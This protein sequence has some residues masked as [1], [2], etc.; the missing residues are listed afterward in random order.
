MGGSVYDYGWRDSYKIEY[1][2]G[3]DIKYGCFFDEFGWEFCQEG[4]CCQDM[5][6]FGIFIIKVW[7]FYDKSDEI[8]NLYFILNKV[9]LIN[10]NLKQN[11]GYFKQYLLDV[12]LRMK[13][14]FFFFYIKLERI[15]SKK[16]LIIL[17]FFCLGL[18]FQVQSYQKIL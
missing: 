8:K 5:I 7:F 12:F 18:F 3:M 6:C 9:L 10:S 2:G 4:C 14:L 13:R 17:L 15:M 11:L 16:I 1:D